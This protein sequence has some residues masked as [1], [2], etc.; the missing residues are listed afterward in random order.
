MFSGL[1]VTEQLCSICN[2][3]ALS[4]IELQFLDEPIITYKRKMTHPFSN[5]NVK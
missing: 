4:K 1:L 5:I 3:K 2:R